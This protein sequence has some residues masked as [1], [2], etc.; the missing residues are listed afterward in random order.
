LECWGWV[1]LGVDRWFLACFEGGWK[2]FNLVAVRDG[3][4][5]RASSRFFPFDYAQGQNDNSK[6]AKAKAKATARA[7][8]KARAK[9]TPMQGSLHF[10]ALRS[11]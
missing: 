9:A 10:A 2:E 5:G 3:K 7:R 11:R 1:G 4:N 8:A 6:K